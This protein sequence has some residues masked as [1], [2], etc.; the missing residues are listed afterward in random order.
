MHPAPSDQNPLLYEFSKYLASSGKHDPLKTIFVTT[1]P[2]YSVPLLLFILSVTALPQVKYDK[3][4]V[5]LARRDKKKGIDGAALIVG[6]A[7]ILKQFHSAYVMDFMSYMGQF[8]RATMHHTLT[9]SKSG[10]NAT[11]P[12]E[13]ANA[14]IFLEHFVQFSGIDRSILNSVMPNATVDL[15][16]YAKGDV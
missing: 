7:T 15:L 11:L 1:E 14:I 5:A 13:V 4:L 6:I 3:N 12:Y 9:P 2:L 8:I 16:R 10:R